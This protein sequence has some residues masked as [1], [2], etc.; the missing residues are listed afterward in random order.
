M[1]NNKAPKKI[2]KRYFTFFGGIAFCLF[3]VILILNGKYVART[4]AFPFAY[5]FG[6]GSY[7]IYILIY[8]FGLCLFFRE[9]GF[10]IRPNNY[11]FGG[12]FIFISILII[13]TLIVTA[14]K[15]EVTLS[16]FQS[17]YKNVMSNIEAEGDPNSYWKATFVNLFQ[18]NAFGGGFVGYFLAGALSTPTGGKPALAWVVAILIALLGIFLIF[19]PQF[20]KIFKGNKATKAPKESKNREEERVISTRRVEN[21]DNIS[22]ASTLDDANNEPSPIYAPQINR[23]AN[24]NERND[25]LRPVSEDNSSNN[26]FGMSTNFVPARFGKFMPKAPVVEK[27]EEVKP[28]TAEQAIMEANRETTINEQMQLNFEEK[29]TVNM[30]LAS[31]KPEFVEPVSV[32]PTPNPI[33]TPMEA[34]PTPVQPAPQPVVKK[35]IKWIPPSGELLET[36]EVQ[37]AIDENN[38]V[39]EERVALI[40][41]VFNDFGVGATC[42]SYVIGP[43]V[44]RYNIEYSSNVSVRSVNNLLPDL[45][46]RLNGVD[47]LFE[48]RVEG[49]R[50][51]G[52]EIAN[53]KITSVSF[54]EVYESLP[55]AKKKPLHVAFGKNIDGRIIAADFN[56]FPHIL[57]AGTTGSGKSVFTHSLICTLIMRNSPDNL[58]LVLIDPKKVEMSKYRDIPHLLCP[59]INDPNVAKLTMDKLVEEM[60]RRYD[61]L[62][63]NGCSDIKQYNE[64]REENITLEPMPFIVVF[65][66]EFADIVDTCKEVKQPVVSIAQ[67]ARACGIHMLIATQRPSTNIID[68]VIKGNLPTRVAL[69]VA[70]QVDS[71]TILGEGGAE[72][73]LGRGDM[74]VQSPLISRTGRVRLQSCYIQ[75]K[76]ILRIVGYLKEHYEVN[77]DPNFC[78]LLENA[79]KAAAEVIGSPEFQ[80][81]LD[82]SEEEKY[83]SVKEWVMANEYMS[84]SRI[85]RECSVGFNRAGRFFKRL[86]DEGIVDTETEGNKGCPVLV[87]DKF[88]DGSS[89]TDVAVS[90]DQSEIL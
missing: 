30:E 75:N 50:Y 5:A 15:T 66:D 88:Y 11:F 16:N 90:S 7:A 70:M 35:P 44:T 57:V 51:S 10:K 56:D 78:N 58:R 33:P 13:S 14:N 61:V 37:D 9:K 40:N 45:N 28:M 49:Q 47:A 87:H 89:D 79:Q 43:S 81:S 1:P 32:M 74:L 67:K 12:L 8:S 46:V 27:P 68:G 86:Q 4:L 77:Y 22:S 85:Q 19:L 62:E 42:Q 36:L 31:K 64:L 6:L 82:N 20:I 21:I 63:L 84:M 80:A 23:Q 34:I 2:S 3:S 25:D 41:E 76:E 48:G 18:G 54:K 38:R 69:A 26:A 59:I 17:L 52:L 73:L 65:I 24:F 83:Q 60:N 39:A 71:V 55:D 72:K 53:A 29:Q